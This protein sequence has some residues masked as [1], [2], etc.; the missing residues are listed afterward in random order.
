MFN[1]SVLNELLRL[2]DYVEYMSL[3][4]R[5][6][7]YDLWRGMIDCVCSLLSNIL[8]LC[9]LANICLRVLL[10][11]L[12]VDCAIV[13]DPLLQYVSSAGNIELS[14]CDESSHYLHS[15]WLNLLTKVVLHCWSLH[16][17][18]IKTFTKESFVNICIKMTECKFF[19]I[20]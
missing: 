12:G 11:K 10:A 17:S 3:M 14:I 13:R 15:S 4:C 20:N 1:R 6:F 19:C 9:V 2:T 18:E 5:W 16:A 8:T 7:G